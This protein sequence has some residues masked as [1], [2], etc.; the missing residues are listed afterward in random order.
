[1]WQVPWWLDAQ[2]L[3]THLTQPQAI[4][5]TGMRTALLGIGAGGRA[6][7][8]ILYTHRTL[9][10]N[11]EGQVTDR[12]TKAISQIASDKPVEQLGGIYALERIMRDSAKDHVTIVE[13]LAAFVREHAPAP[14]EPTVANWFRFIIRRATSMSAGR[15]TGC[16]AYGTAP[17]RTAPGCADRPR[18]P[19]PGPRRAFPYQPEAHRSTRREPSPGPP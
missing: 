5:V 13:V 19:A 17:A 15:G 6:A 9:H 4:T 2:Y 14:A 18:P 8:G 1:M 16:A 3:N 10:Q 12:Y 7:V 11:R